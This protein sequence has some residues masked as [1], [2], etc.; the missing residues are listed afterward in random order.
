MVL[1][2]VKYFLLCV[3]FIFKMRKHLKS[4]RLE[5]LEQV[6]DD[7]IIDIQ[8]GSGEAAYHVILELYDRVRRYFFFVY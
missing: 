8:F 5:K 6:G 3:F 4:R 7:R 2:R 1:K